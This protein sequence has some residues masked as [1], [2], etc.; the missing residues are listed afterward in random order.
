MTSE[1]PGPQP[2]TT[3][4]PGPAEI[5]VRVP[6]LKQGDQGAGVRT[7][8]GLLIARRYHLGVTGAHEDGVDGDFGPLTTEAVRDAQEQ[9]DLDATGVVSAATWLALLE[10]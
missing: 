8:Q 6:E 2:V 3:P 1:T 5:S 4:A 10:F 7:L 9:H